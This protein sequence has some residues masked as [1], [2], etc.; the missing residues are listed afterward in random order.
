MTC[1]KQFFILMFVWLI[2]LPSPNL[3]WCFI[4]VIEAVHLLWYFQA[5]LSLRLFPILWPLPQQPTTNYQMR[6]ISQTFWCRFKSWIPKIYINIY[7][8]L[9]FCYASI[10]QMKLIRKLDYCWILR[11]TNFISVGL[12]RSVYLLKLTGFLSVTWPMQRAAPLM[13]LV[14]LSYFCYLLLVSY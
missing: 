11:L 14:Y 10:S 9:F 8:N 4:F 3:I 2:W 5:V 7:F 1:T 13:D 12:S 6:I